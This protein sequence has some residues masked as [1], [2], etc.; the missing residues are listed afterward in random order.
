MRDAAPAASQAIISGTKVDGLVRTRQGDSV[1]AALGGGHES[2]AVG[3]MP[4]GII[5]VVQ[6]VHRGHDTVP[7]MPCLRR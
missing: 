6:T 5:E 4:D 3:Q 2:V 7:P 1:V